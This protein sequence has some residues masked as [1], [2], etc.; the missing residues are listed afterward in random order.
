MQIIRN[1]EVANFIFVPTEEKET[2]VLNQIIAIAKPDDK[3]T[4]GG[5]NGGDGDKPFVVYL[6][7]GSHTEENMTIHRDEEVGGVKLELRG[8]GEDSDNE[9]RLIR[10]VCFFGSG[11][12]IFLGTCE[13]DGKTAIIVTA[14]KCKLCGGPMISMA[15]CEW[16]T[17]DACASKCEHDYVSG[18]VHGGNVG[19]MG[20]GEF[21]DKCGRGKP[22]PEGARKKNQIE[23]ELEVERELG[24]KVFYK[25]GPVQT[26]RE[27]A[28]LNRVIRRHHKALSRKPVKV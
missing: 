17:C 7:L 20:I 9:V 21:C 16:R 13:V 4:Y 23:R 5:R 18:M 8:S 19:N 27:A 25:E 1:K 22:E 28:E 14:S 11:G 6:H 15:S 3:M 2:E 24:V 12:L 10:D 26:P